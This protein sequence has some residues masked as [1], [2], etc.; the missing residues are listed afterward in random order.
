MFLIP[1][2]TELNSGQ[3]ERGPDREKQHAF[4]SIARALPFPLVHHMFFQVC[5]EHNSIVMPGIPGSI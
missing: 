1:K 3:G 2:G 4:P 5:F